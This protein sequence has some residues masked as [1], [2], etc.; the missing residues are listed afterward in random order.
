MKSVLLNFIAMRGKIC[1]MVIYMSEILSNYKI[2]AGIG[3]GG[4]I[5]KNVQYEQ[6]TKTINPNQHCIKFFAKCDFI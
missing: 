5:F 3:H 6:P 1:V 2:G 4:H